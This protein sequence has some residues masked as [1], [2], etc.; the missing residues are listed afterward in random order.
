PGGL[1]VM[2]DVSWYW[3]P[4]SERVSIGVKSPPFS[5]FSVQN[6]TMLNGVSI[7]RSEKRLAFV[8]IM[9]KIAYSM[10][11]ATNPA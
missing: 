5:S 7:N 4:D 8:T 6:I 1:L 3:L 10:L 9:R 2:S 11:V